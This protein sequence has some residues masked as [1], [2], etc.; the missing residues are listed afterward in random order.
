[1]PRSVASSTAAPKY[2]TALMDPNRIIFG[3]R[4]AEETVSTRPLPGTPSGRK[5]TYVTVDVASRPRYSHD[6]DGWVS[7]PGQRVMKR[8]AHRAARLQ[9]RKG[10]LGSTTASLR[11]PTSSAEEP[12]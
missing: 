2:A 11:E 7:V 1:M 4:F 5:A 6:E 8:R 10:W 9:E 3:A 12:L